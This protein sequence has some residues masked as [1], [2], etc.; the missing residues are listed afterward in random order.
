M[1]IHK[2]APTMRVV[3]PTMRVV[4]LTK[5]VV[6][7]TIRVVAPTM[8]VVALTFDKVA[9]TFHHIHKKIS[10]SKLLGNHS[11]NNLNICLRHNS[12]KIRHYKILYPHLPIKRVYLRIKT[13][14][15]N[16]EIQDI[17]RNSLIHFLSP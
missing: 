13:Q 8:H 16:P 14:N 11:R 9:V 17:H 3:A 4:A 15:G 7:P 6:A 5:R 2:V 12:G 1:N 10:P